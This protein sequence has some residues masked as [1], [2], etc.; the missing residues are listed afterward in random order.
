MPIGYLFIHTS[1]EDTAVCFTYI[2]IPSPDYNRIQILWTHSY[3]PL[4]GLLQSGL[5]L[6]LSL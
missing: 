3:G 1:T 4:H 2:K 6:I 5:M